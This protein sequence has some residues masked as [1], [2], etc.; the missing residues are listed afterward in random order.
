LDIRITGNRLALAAVVS[1]G[2]VSVMVA[3]CF[4]SYSLDERGYPGG[5]RSSPDIAGGVAAG[6]GSDIRMPTIATEESD[7]FI[8]DQS[9]SFEDKPTPLAIQGL[10]THGSRTRRQVALTFDACEVNSAAYD[11]GVVNDLIQAHAPATLFL[12]GKW[13]LDHPAAT[14]ELAS[15]S[16][17]ELANHSYSH[18]HF[19]RLITAQILDQVIM[20]QDILF[21]LTGRRAR[22]FRF[23]Y[24]EWT[25]TAIPEINSLGL[26]TIQWDVVSGDPS[27]RQTAPLL[28]ATVLRLAQNGSII[29]MHMNGRGW[30]TAE[31]LPTIISALRARGFTLVTVS[32]LLADGQTPTQTLGDLGSAR[33]AH[34]KVE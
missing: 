5:K 3:I 21:D 33:T 17:L 8:P 13:M 22:L 30:H 14:R 25:S 31:A 18:P 28:I 23:P 9:P 1:V 15:V 11:A 16:F 6:A 4:H 12:G 29:V 2:A 24:G 7:S 10:I 34:P 20:T 26:Q 32:Q 19:P 27:P